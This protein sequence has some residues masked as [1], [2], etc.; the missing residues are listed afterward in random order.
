[1]NDVRAEGVKEPG[2]AGSFA[3]ILFMVLVAANALQAF[4]S[5]GPPPFIGQGDPIRL[6][7]NP[8][9]WLWSREE[10]TGRLSLRGSWTFAPPDVAALD[11][12]TAHGP[13]ANLPALPVL[14]WTRVSA[15][16]DGKLSD[17]A[18]DGASGTFLAVTDRHE[19]VMLD[20]TLARVVRSVRLD[21]GWSID[22]TPLAGAAFAGD[23]L[24]VLA[25]NKSYV[26]LRADPQADAD[27][28]WRHFLSTSGGV[29]ELRRSRWA[30]VRA[31]QMYVMSMA[32]DPAAREFVTVSVPNPRHLQ[33]VVSRFARGDMTLSSE[34][35][36]R[37][38]DGLVARD[39]SRS[40]AEYVVTGATV[41]DGTLYGISAAYG[42]LLAI[43]L[44][45]R[46][47]RG[48][49]TIGGLTRPVGLAARGTQLLVAQ[50]DGRIALV[51]RPGP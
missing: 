28:E 19:V 13:L 6:S 14:G 18:Y 51:E 44:G 32:Y 8:R 27:A 48:A 39:S 7:L 11:G 3:M 20:S 4:A 22:L 41:V 50:A 47:L 42:T 46:T 12:D 2:R 30:T 38:A 25:T 16:L 37:L 23:T 49:W 45:T 33:L 40:V 35:E 17:L 21:P 5:T 34:F 24:A 1:M 26:L 29:T 9:R 43:D 15:P 36:P 31:R 10:A